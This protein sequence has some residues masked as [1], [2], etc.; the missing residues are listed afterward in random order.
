MFLGPDAVSL[1]GVELGGEPTGLRLP[2]LQPLAGPPAASWPRG[3]EPPHPANKPP[4]AARRRPGHHL[5]PATLCLLHAVGAHGTDAE[6]GRQS[7]SQSAGQSP[8]PAARGL[9]TRCRIRLHL[10]SGRPPAAGLRLN[11]RVE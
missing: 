9:G 8:P 5:P 7:A 6:P 2:Y 3:I 11:C 1:D 10:A 4:P